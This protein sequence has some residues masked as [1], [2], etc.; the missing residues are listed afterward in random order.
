MV[1]VTIEALEDLLV[2]PSTHETNFHNDLQGNMFTNI[3]LRFVDQAN[4]RHFE[5]VRQEYINSLI[6]SLQRRFPQS[7]MDILTD[8]S[9]KDEINVSITLSVFRDKGHVWTVTQY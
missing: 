4:R 3:E 1:N 6:T 8:M 2:N 7:D 9:T 5:R